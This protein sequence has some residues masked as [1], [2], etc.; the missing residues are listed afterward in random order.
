M[1]TLY[2]A[3]Q[4]SC[5]WRVRIALNL[6]NID[7]T[8]E[9]IDLDNVNE[10]YAKKNPRKAIPALE[11]DG[12]LLTQ[13]LAIIEYLEET[14]PNQGVTLLPKDPYLRA[15][16]RR[17]CL[18]VVAD[19]QPLQNRPVLRKVDGYGQDSKEWARHWIELNFGAIEDLLQETEQNGFCVGGELS[20]ADACL[21]PQYYKAKGFGVNVD[22]FA[23]MSKIIANLSKLDQFERADPRHQPDFK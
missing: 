14:R 8:Y 22:Q 20:M 10:E 4:S 15:L 12:R 18:S 5:S 23:T 21:L 19:V 3:H 13:S 11:I 16:V 6:K 17:I 2:N 9:A 7:F 1:T